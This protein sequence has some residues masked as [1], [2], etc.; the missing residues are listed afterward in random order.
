M[1]GRAIAVAVLVCCAPI[2]VVVGLAIAIDSRGP[3]LFRQQRIGRGYEPFTILKFRSMKHGHSN[4]R[5][6][7][8]NRREL[9]G[10]P[11]LDGPVAYKDVD[12]PGITRV[13]KVLRCYSLDELPQLWNVVRGD[14]ALVGPRPSLP[15]EVEE[16]PAWAEPRFSV[17]PG[18]TGQWQVSGRN[19]VSMLGM[20]E[21]DV[22][23]ARSKSAFGDLS[24]VIRT[25][26][27][28][29]RPDGSA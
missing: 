4:G 15:W 22:D 24:I 20:L 5:H 11:P 25:I 1:A 9:A 14:M 3:V 17:L 7:E 27:A 6:R 19:Q 21:M 18:L 16:F 28:V 2:L 13:G 26:P 8:L 10:G 29:L 23:Y 12:D